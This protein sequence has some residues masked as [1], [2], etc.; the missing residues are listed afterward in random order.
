M[1]ANAQS[2]S[3]ATA[4]SS[5]KGSR[6]SLGDP[7]DVFEHTEYE[8][9]DEI[10]RGGMGLVYRA[11]HRKLKR[12][13]AVKLLT[14]RRIEDAQAVARFLREMEIV[15]QLD[16]PH[17]VRAHD[18]G[19]IDGVHFL[20]MELV[21]GIDLHHLVR[22][23]GPLSVADACELTRQAAIG[24]QYA[25][26]R[27]LVHQD[28][29]P[30]N[31][32][33]SREGV[34]KVA[35]LGLARLDT[36]R[37]SADLLNSSDRIVG[38]FDFMAP[39]QA[40]G[41]QHVDIAA[42]IYGLGCTLFYLL[43]GRAPFAHP[44]HD[45]PVKKILAHVAEPPP[46]AHEVRSDIPLPVSQI[47]ERALAKKPQD[48]FPQPAEVAE[49]LAPFTAGCDLPRLAAK[50]IDE[51]ASVAALVAGEPDPF[52]K[53]KSFHRAVPSTDPAT[54]RRAAP[55]PAKP[56]VA[57]W[58]WAGATLAAAGIGIYL[59]QQ[60]PG[61]PERLV[62]GAD[63]APVITPPGKPAPGAAEDWTRELGQAPKELVYPGRKGEGRWHIDDQTRS[64][65][66]ASD[67]VR[68]IKLGE[69]DGKPCRIEVDVQQPDWGGSVGVFLGYREDLT[70]TKQLT[71]RF[72]LI[73][74]EK[75]GSGPADADLPGR[76]KERSPFELVRKS[77]YLD[78][79]SPDSTP[80]LGIPYGERVPYPLDGQPL[81]LVLH[82]GPRG[83]TRVSWGGAEI[84]TLMRE[85]VNQQYTARDY[86]GPWGLYLHHAAAWF[87]RPKFERL[88]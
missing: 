33:L 76:G 8:L 65:E 16:H 52:A 35:D 27:G 6:V 4:V 63:P 17:L 20:A 44:S 41:S 86:H 37:E 60:P 12:P 83:L 51:L 15:G 84:G 71:G 34:V 54:T 11:I 28:V 29:K 80:V 62:D 74:L 38:T 73:S 75:T 56:R 43:V 79:Q 22:A 23:V 72:Q 55:P 26:Q 48:R 46:A 13:V 81:R 31:L 32:L 18:A 25:H 24:L 82:I 19:E 77:T 59:T 64:L 57:W 85:D 1:A 61:N 30:S 10:G 40:H 5:R 7:R 53:T 45:T 88:D 68:L 42:D 78:P 47:I 3:A 9:G 2:D 58:V 49:A 70:T 21:E 14:D 69:L 36:W 87:S 50:A 67:S 66:L 39:E